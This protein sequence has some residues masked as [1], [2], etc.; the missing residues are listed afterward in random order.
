MQWGKWVLE[1]F[2]RKPGN[3]NF[4]YRNVLNGNT[5]SEDGYFS[6]EQLDSKA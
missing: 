3:E 1:R 2:C 5:L 6:F 4:K